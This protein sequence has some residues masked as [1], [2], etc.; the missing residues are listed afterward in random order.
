MSELVQGRYWQVYDAGEYSSHEKVPNRNR[1]AHRGSGVSILIAPGGAEGKLP[2]HRLPRSMHSRAAR[3]VDERGRSKLSQ[4]SSTFFLSGAQRFLLRSLSSWAIRS[5]S[6]CSWQ[7]S[8]NGDLTG[9][10]FFIPTSY[11]SFPLF[12]RAFLYLHT[13]AGIRS[14]SFS[15][16]VNC[17]KSL[18]T[19]LPAPRI[20]LRPPRPLAPPASA[21][22]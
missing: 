12:C 16:F 21:A 22:D 14:P 1:K 19:S 4:S 7:S 6:R 15:P 17:L 20:H 11:I 13:E 10:G 8:D 5:T 9:S 3:K 18:F 2:A